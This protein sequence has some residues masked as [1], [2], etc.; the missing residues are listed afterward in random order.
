LVGSIRSYFQRVLRIQFGLPH[1]PNSISW[2]D[3]RSG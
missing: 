2:M 3:C 1:H